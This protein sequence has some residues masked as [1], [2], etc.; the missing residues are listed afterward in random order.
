MDNNKKRIAKLVTIEYTVRVLA[1]TNEMPEVE[2]E[3]ILNAAM[4]KIKAN[5]VNDICWDN[6]TDIEDDNEC[7]YGTFKDDIT[8]D[9][10]KALFG[11]YT[12]AADYIGDN[13]GYYLA[14]DII[15]EGADILMENLELIS[16]F[17]KMFDVLTQCVYF[18]NK[19]FDH[20]LTFEEYAAKGDEI[21]EEIS[22]FLGEFFND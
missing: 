18:I 9:L 20:D 16:P 15:N 4:T 8:P 22:G 6:V 19:D 1:N 10:R 21:I 12:E 5:I 11:L 2:E 3:D 14:S 17:E 7:P 13:K